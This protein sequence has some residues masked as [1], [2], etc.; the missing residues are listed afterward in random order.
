MV[1]EVLGVLGHLGAGELGVVGV[2]P[3]HDMVIHVGVHGRIFVVKDLPL[4]QKAGL[5]LV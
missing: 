4:D 3:R 5:S 2:L 1:S